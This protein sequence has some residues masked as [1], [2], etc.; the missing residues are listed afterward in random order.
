MQSKIEEIR[1]E[2]EEKIVT[3]KNKAAASYYKDN[4]SIAMIDEGIELLSSKS[5]D[6]SIINTIVIPYAP[7]TAQDTSSDI[8][9]PTLH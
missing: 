7:S 8:P 1:K 2:A 6:I 5:K 9:Q 3:M 4:D